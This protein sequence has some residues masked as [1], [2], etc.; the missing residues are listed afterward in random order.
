MLKFVFFCDTA[1]FNWIE[2][3]VVAIDLI[4]NAMFCCVLFYF[5]VS[6]WY[7]LPYSCGVGRFRRKSEEID[8]YQIDSTIKR[9]DIS[10]IHRLGT[11]GSFSQYSF[12]LDGVSKFIADLIS[13]DLRRSSYVILG[14]KTV[15]M[16]VLMQSFNLMLA[17][18]I[19]LITLEPGGRAVLP[20]LR[21]LGCT[22]LISK[23]SVG[24]RSVGS[25][26]RPSGQLFI[27]CCFSRM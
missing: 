17:C 9:E 5:L 13:L 19:S 14:R 26:L 16:V 8:G 11:V 1:E 20:W 6:I 7:R 27:I 22:Q 21:I 25:S 15:S 24:R 18:L 23:W 10:S 4:G 2:S 3:I 12:R